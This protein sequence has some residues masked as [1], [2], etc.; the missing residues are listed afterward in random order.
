MQHTSFPYTLA[1]ASKPVRVETSAVIVKRQSAT[2]D[3]VRS[4]FAYQFL[5]HPEKKSIYASEQ[6]LESAEDVELPLKL[7]PVDA[8]LL[9]KELCQADKNEIF[10]AV[11]RTARLQ[12]LDGKSWINCLLTAHPLPAHYRDLLGWQ[13]KAHID[14]PIAQEAVNTGNSEVL[15]FL[16]KI[17]KAGIWHYNPANGLL[18]LDE[19]LQQLL[20]IQDAL[21]SSHTLQPRL[22]IADRKLLLKNIFTL[23]RKKAFFEQKI[24]VKFSDELPYQTITLIGGSYL[25]QTGNYCISGLCFE[26]SSNALLQGTSSLH[27]PHKEVDLQLAKIS[28]FNWNPLRQ[29][30]NSS[31][32]FAEVLGLSPEESP[33]LSALQSRLMPADFCALTTAFDNIQAGAEK[34]ELTFTIMNGC[35]VPQHFWLLAKG[36]YKDNA[37]MS[38]KGYVQDISDRAE[39]PLQIQ[40]KERL[41]GGFLKNLPVSIMAINDEQKIVSVVGSGLQKAGFARRKML[42]AA[43]EDVFDDFAPAIRKVLKGVSQSF[44]VEQTVKKQVVSLFNHY[45]YDKTRKMAVGF[46]L[47]ISQ[48]KRAELATKHLDQLEQRYQL[49]DTF[50]HAVA[51]DLRSPVVNLDM[52][53]NFMQAEPMLPE[54]EKYVKAMSTGV[55]HLKRTLDALI[56]ILRIEKDSSLT[57]EDIS[58]KE[59]INEL[60]EEFSI[61]LKKANVCLQTFLQC[62]SICY[63]RAYLTSILRNLLSNAI[64]YTYP[65]RPPQITIC[66]EK[67]KDLVLLTVQDNGMGMDLKKWGHLLFKPFKRLNNHKKGTGIGL[68]LIQQIVEKNGGKIKVSSEPGKGSS[69]SCFLRPH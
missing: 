23:Q 30:L 58:F 66:T 39:K 42:G 16:S 2:E 46:T 62:E 63:N 25:N 49:M 47:D 9:F 38:I 56:E 4:D 36:Q 29:Q 13:V 22:H 12:A 7:H 67:R 53:I 48:Q 10:K 61:K 51:H 65:N 31:Q 35:G 52:I 24:R 8:E 54:Q 26:S 37:L 64:K 50:V 68:H 3:T 1:P 55:L 33:T 20:H 45:Y 21:V 69:F 34:Q 41:I 18:Q 44:I 17:Y 5:V 59:I 14:I 32:N 28:F 27:H 6:V 11:E 15:K 60:E 57:V 19:L 43:V 40:A